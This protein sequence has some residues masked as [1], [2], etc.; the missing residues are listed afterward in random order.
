MSTSAVQVKVG[1]A[2]TTDLD[3][4][5]AELGETRLHFAAGIPGFREARD[6]IARP[7]GPQP[8]P[9]VVLE[10]EELP[11]VR[12]VAAPPGIFFPTYQP[13][14]SP[15]VYGAIEAGGP[16]DTLVLVF[17][18]L[19]SRPEDTTANLLGPLV[20]NSRTG[21][22]IQAVLSGSGLSPEA[23]VLGDR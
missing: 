9:F 5:T 8:S 4:A 19:R 22:A 20:I 15:D 3:E 2:I 6:F 17:L 23:R 7:W 14:F 11:G 1:S 10:C 12:F 16:E 18:T 13:A 21:Q